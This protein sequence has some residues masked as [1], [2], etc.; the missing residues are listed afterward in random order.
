MFWFYGSK[1]CGILAPRPGIKP[2][3][4]ALER[5]DINHW[6]TR[7]ILLLWYIRKS[8]MLDSSLAHLSALWPQVSLWNSL[9]LAFLVSNKDHPYSIA[10]WLWTKKWVIVGKSHFKL[11][12]LQHK[13]L[14]LLLLELSQSEYLCWKP[15]SGNRGKKCEYISSG[16]LPALQGSIC[17]REGSNCYNK[18]ARQELVFWC[19]K[20]DDL[21]FPTLTMR[22]S[23]WGET[24]VCS[25]PP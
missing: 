8:K 9:N 5:W 17:P 22:S 15:H 13:G 3:S 7:E 4:P 25:K 12:N 20:E 10:G 1:V 6:T 2:T 16:F 21:E 19:M 14:L 24:K 23:L 18:D 11:H